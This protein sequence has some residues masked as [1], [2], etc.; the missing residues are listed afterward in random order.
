MG[1]PA[2][3]AAAIHLYVRSRF[4]HLHLLMPVGGLC[5]TVFGVGP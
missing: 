5:P 4:S 1:L 3:L 2:G